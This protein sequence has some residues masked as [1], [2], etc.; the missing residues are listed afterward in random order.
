MTEALPLLLSILEHK[1][2]K[3]KYKHFGEFYRAKY[4]T[5]AF[6]FSDD[7]GMISAILRQYFATQVKSMYE[8]KSFSYDTLID[9]IRPVVLK[10]L[11]V[12][13]YTLKSTWSVE[14]CDIIH[15]NNA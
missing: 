1:D 9:V 5:F 11:D 8:Y 13:K 2:S 12:F 3:L 15:R 4:N 14:H 6:Q 10:N 7:N